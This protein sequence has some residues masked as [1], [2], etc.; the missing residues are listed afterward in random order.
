VPNVAEFVE[1]QVVHA[2][3]CDGHAEALAQ[4]GCVEDMPGRRVPEDEVMVAAVVRSLEVAL[5]LAGEPVGHRD[6]APA[7]R[8]RGVRA[9]DGEREDAVQ[10][11]EM[12]LHRLGRQPVAAL[13]GR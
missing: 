1:R 7:M 10:E 8:L 11:V 6:R 4:P 5:E 2:R 13:G 12:V 3:A 9:P